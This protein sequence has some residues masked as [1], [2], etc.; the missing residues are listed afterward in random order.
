MNKEEAEAWAKEVCENGSFPERVAY[1]SKFGVGELAKYNWYGPLF[2][3]GI[4]Y[5]ILIAVAKIYGELEE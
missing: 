4:E 5:G 1:I 2:T 3:L